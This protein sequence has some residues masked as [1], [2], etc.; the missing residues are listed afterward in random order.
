MPWHFGSAYDL[1]RW[2][3]TFDLQIQI[4]FE[5][6]YGAGAEGY[7][8]YLPLNGWKPKQPVLDKNNLDWTR[9]LERSGGSL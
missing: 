7:T 1:I 9:P 6:L 4:Q 5:T 3:E 2:E 8:D